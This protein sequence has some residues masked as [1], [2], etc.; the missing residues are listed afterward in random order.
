MILSVLT[1]IAGIISVA[2][3]LIVL[4]VGTNTKSMRVAYGMFAT[5][6]GLWAIFLG[7]FLVMP[8]SSSVGL[9]V[10]IYYSLGLLIPYSFLIFC[11]AYLSIHVSHAVRV[12]ALLPWVVMSILI[13]IPGGMISSI[14]TGPAKTVELV[15]S[16][17]ILYTAVFV[18]Y[19]AMGM[20]FL[21]T[22]A[23]RAKG[24]YAHR[25]VV[26]LSLAIGFSGGGFFDIILPLF[27]NYQLIVY[28]PL[29]AFITSAGIFY[30]IAKHG[31]FDIRL[32]AM[33]TFAY[34]LTL[35]SLSGIYYVLASF[36]S[37]IVLHTQGQTDATLLSPFTIILALALAFIFQ[38]IKRLFDKLTNLVFYRDTYDTT[39]FFTRI[40]RKTSTISDLY[41]LLHYAS[42][43][44]TDTLKAQFG[45]F[46]IHERGKRP[47]FVATDKHTPFPLTDLEQLSDY[48]AQTR[49]TVVMVNRLGESKEDRV[50][51]RMLK[52]YRVALVLPIINEELVSSFLFLGEHRSSRYSDRD[53]EALSTIADE[54]GI[55][56]RNALSIHEVKNL[57]ATLQQRID[58]A[59]KELRASNAQLQKLDEAKDEFISMASHQLRTPLT[60]IKGYISM[61]IDGD[62]GAVSKE[63]KHLLEEAFMSSERMVRLIGDFLNVS[64]LQTGKFVIDKHPVDLAKIVGDEVESL[65]TNAKSHSLK[66][67]Y[68]KP[69]NVPLLNLDENK[70]QQVIM[71]FCDNAIYYSKENSKI[72]VSLAVVGSHV[73]FK[74][75]DSGIGVPVAEQEQLF[76]KFFRATNAR[77]QRPDGTGVGLFLAKKVI[78]AH[79]GTIVF[80]SKEGKGSTFGFRLPIKKA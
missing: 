53:V 14:D 20:W 73:E 56:I 67:T 66:F 19:V 33:R 55:A 40:T 30:V 54:L 12:F 18:L 16:N 50:I 72:Q 24:V 65:E 80:E 2:L 4:T 61:L 52:S 57:N 78:D 17:Y 28:G 48:I 21:I 77:K 13:A 76:N 74:V 37:Q 29:F 27:G 26:A 46:S 58:S 6:V 64:R 7:L 69:R 10:Y 34:V 71:N 8:P 47:I 62:V 38:P 11:F 43:D 35:A 79:K 51:Q 25:R 44:I 60:S 36:V 68:K 42:S 32:A 1:I 31:L 39:E 5:S 70:I 59:T 9:I 15:Q 75:K 41:T 22:K 3:G 49:A 63:Q 45:A 23:A